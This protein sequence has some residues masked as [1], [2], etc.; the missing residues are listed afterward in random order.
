M[1]AVAAAS[2]DLTDTIAVRSEQ[3][4]RAPVGRDEAIA[5]IRSALRRRS[6]K[7]WSVK[8]DRGTA[9]GW[10]TIS[11]PPRRCGEYGYMTDEDRAELGRLLGLEGPA[12]TQGVSI[13]ASSD[14]RAEYVAR[15]EGRAP[16][17]FGKQYWD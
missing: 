17:T 2:P 8:G 5:A 14:Y 16:A 3:T 10:I 6:G 4:G 11:A 13:A 7:S 9:W 12:H 15:A 1:S